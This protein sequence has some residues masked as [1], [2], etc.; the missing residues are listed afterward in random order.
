M[1]SYRDSN[2]SNKDIFFASWTPRLLGVLRIITGFLFI[3]HG[4]QK[5]VNYPASDHGAVPLLSFMG[6][7]G[8]LELFGGMLILVG[9]FTRPTAFVLSGAMAVAYFIAHAPGGF[10]PIVNK[11][12]LAVIYCFVFLFLSVAGG[13]SFSVDSVLRKSRATV[14][15][16]AN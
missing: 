15:A 5:L 16:E 6:F 3:A 12:E 8:S 1:I 9:L 7:T 10:L 14:V 2:M 13:G 4:T 11:G